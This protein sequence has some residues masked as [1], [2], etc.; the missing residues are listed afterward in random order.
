MKKFTCTL[1]LLLSVSIFLKA[2]DPHFSQFFAS[3]LTLN[4]ALT[5]KFDGTLRVAGNYRNQWPAFNN[6]YTT[7]TLSVDFAIL[8]NKLPDFDTW[9]V[10]ILALTD[11]AGG[12]ILTNNYV[13][14]STSYHKALD[15]DGFQQLGIGFQGTY[16][17]KRLDNSKL[18]FE[19]Q[20]T[21]FGF[22]GVTQDIFSSSNLNINYLDVNA[23]IIYTGSTN[24]QNN[25]YIGASM[26]HINRP[27]ES[28]KGGNW[29]IAARTTVSAGGYFPVSEQLTL[30]TSGIYQVQNKSSEVSLGGAI[31]ASIDPESSSPSNV[32]IGSWY[33][34]GD[35]IIPY[36]GLEFAGMRIGA[37]YDINISDLKAGSQSRGGMEISLI[38]IKRPVGYKGI[39]CPKF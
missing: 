18:Y 17:Q 37:T 13:G 2:Q 31:A 32:Y 11:K 16:G 35:A 4:P 8:K 21:P 15:E 12:G 22:T 39:P 34:V 9:G 27:K 28:F 19:D 33:R 23:G 5:G 20:L 3:P 1:L 6:V 30:H 7:S 29:N 38:Y 25:F 24:D 26:Y 14:L 36:V 10:G